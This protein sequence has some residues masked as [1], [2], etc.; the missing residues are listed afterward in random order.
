MSA[1]DD[2]QLIADYV[3][4]LETA[5]SALPPDRAAELVEEITAHIAE[6]RSAGADQVGSRSSVRNIIERLGDPTDIVQ[7][8]MDAAPNDAP[9]S[10]TPATA[11]RTPGSATPATADRTP[12]SATPATADRTPG[13]ATPATADRT[14]AGSIPA[15]ADN[16]PGGWNGRPVGG[17][18]DGAAP[19]V[20]ALEICAVIFLLIGGLIVPFIGWVVGVILL[21]V[22]PRWRRADKWLG[23]LVWPGGLLA[24]AI[25]IAVGGFASVMVSSVQSCSSSPIIQ[26]ASQRSGGTVTVI[27][28]GRQAAGDAAS[29]SSGAGWPSWLVISLAV[30]L[31]AAAI[32]G[33][34]FTAVRLLRRARQAP[35]S[36][37]AEPPVPIPA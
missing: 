37:S 34:I 4:R 5:G 19:R 7:A 14:P 17:M 16:P 35:V 30:V 36:A 21:W 31:M 9:G 12:G 11:D 1:Y 3:R 20:G 26:R 32:G 29:C 6:A 13:G 27:N 22:S 23:T 18:P 15:I 2:D 33:P 25:L 24:P 28:H 10:A 8:A